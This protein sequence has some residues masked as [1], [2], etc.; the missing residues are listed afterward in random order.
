MIVS[1]SNQNSKIQNPESPQDYLWLNLRELPYFRALMRAVEAS[2][3][4]EIDLPTPVLDVGC[5]DGHFVTVAFDRLIDVGLDPGRAPLKEASLRGGY[6]S[7]VQADGGQMPFPNDHFGSAF[8]NSVLEHIPHV[9]EVLKEVARV[10]KPGAPFVFCGPNHN[11]LPA[12]SLGRALDRIHLHRF[13][14]AYRTLFNRI[15]RHYH[16]DSSDI[17]QARLE[18]TGFQLQ[19]T[20]NYYSPAALQVTEWGHYFGLPSLLAHALTGRWVLAPKRWN[21]AL[22]ESYTRR[23]FDPSPCHDGVCSFYVAR[24]EA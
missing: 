13:G 22:T 5:G 20:W 10:L 11:F 2:Y 1:E 21:L 17:W 14:D 23:Y 4:S 15:S 9:E 16:S 3:Y 7:L 24:R 18:K 6:R 8:S 19:E 12:L